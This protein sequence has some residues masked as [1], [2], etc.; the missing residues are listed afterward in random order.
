MVTGRP[1]A[2]SGSIGGGQPWDPQLTIYQGSV[3]FEFRVPF[4][5][6]GG[7]A[8]ALTLRLGIGSVRGPAQQGAPPGMSLSAFNFRRGEWQSLPIAPWPVNF[9]AP[10]EYMTKDGR[11]LVK[12][13]AH[14]DSIPLS[15]IGI[16]GQVDTF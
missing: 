16:S 9:P 11:I 12:I 6:K 7:T 1:I 10:V 4:G 2:A 3:I 15:D 5:E 8:R 13:A 14:A